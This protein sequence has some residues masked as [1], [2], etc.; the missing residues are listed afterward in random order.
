MTL[1]TELLVGVITGI[2]GISVAI[3]GF[4]GRNNEVSASSTKTLVEGQGSRIDQLEAR[5]LA[6]EGQ[7]M[8]AHQR[9][10]VAT[11]EN[12]DLR[13]ELLH[14]ADWSEAAVSW[15]DSDRLSPRPSAP[16]L[17]IW[18]ALL[19]VPRPRDPPGEV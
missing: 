6:V 13:R 7:L 17:D 12:H 11:R 9:E 18:R 10:W 15:M 19:S 1:S 5:L 3:I 14:A 4:L 2:V 8:A 16:R